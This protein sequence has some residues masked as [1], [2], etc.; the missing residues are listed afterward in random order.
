M[1]SLADRDTRPEP[2]N[3]RGF[4]RIQF[5]AEERPRLLLDAPGAV[6]LVCEV[7]ECSERGLRFVS[8]SPWMH[9]TGVQV[10]GDVVF[11]RGR[12]VR[13]AGSVVRIQGDEVALLL[14]RSEIPL[15]VILDEQ[16]YLRARYA[17]AE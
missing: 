4:Y 5:P 10:A 17:G 16:R 3:R 13:I 15:G 7:L 14:G 9:G 2:E 1:I 12:R 6:R 11:S 8:Q